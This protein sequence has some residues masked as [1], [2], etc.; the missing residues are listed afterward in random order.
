MPH[1]LVAGHIHEAGLELLGS[2]PGITFRLINEI[3]MESYAPFAGEADAILIRTQRLPAAVIA[4]APRLRIVSRHGV[5]YDAVD[6]AALNARGIPLAVVGDINS[7]AVAEHTLML[8]LATA[9]KAIAYDAATRRGPWNYRNSFESVELDGKTLLVLGFGRI[10]RRVA[11]LAQAFGMT[12]LAHD[13]FVADGDMRKLGVEPA[14]TVDSA[15]GKAD[16]VS[17]HVPLSPAGAAIAGPQI[18][19]MKPS[20]IIINAARGGL[21]DEAA[22]DHALREG[23]LGGAGLDVLAAE[24]PPSDHPL[25]ANPKVTFSPHTAGLT[26][27]CAKRMAISAA[28]NIIDFFNGKLDPQLVVNAKQVLKPGAGG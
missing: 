12:V 4:D 1:I 24:P 15:L 14:E 18:A 11:Q 19:R 13:P 6:V 16:F 23:K 20:A 3:T 17:L 7:R 25:L 10:G 28:Q 26:Q 2:A 22:L 5:G 9:R 27:E 21:I 8:M